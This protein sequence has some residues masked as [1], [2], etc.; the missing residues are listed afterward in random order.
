MTIALALSSNVRIPLLCAAA[1]L[2]A[3]SAP[4]GQGGGIPFPGALDKAAVIQTKIGDIHKEAMVVGNG[5]INAL[6]YSQAGD[7]VVR[8]TKNDVWDSRMDTSEDPDMPTVDVTSRKWTGSR[9]APPSWKKRPYP[10]QV[11]SCVIRVGAGEAVRKATLDLKRGLAEI[12][13]EAAA[14]RVRALWQRNVFLVDTAANVSLEGYKLKFLPPAESGTTDGIRW[15]RQTLP[16][17]GDYQGMSLA[18]ALGAAGRHKAVALVSSHDSATPLKGA[19][20][21]V[22][23]TL[24]EDPKETIRTHEGHWTTFWSASGVQLGIGDFQNWWYRQLYYFRCFSRPGVV[25]IG[26]QAGYNRPAGWHGSYKINYNI[27][28]TF[29]SPFTYNHPDLTKPWVEHLYGYL[30]RARWFARTGFGCEGAAYHAD[31]W[32]HEVDPAKC[33]NRNKNQIA[34]IPWGYTMG[35]SGMAVQN[36]WNYYLYK[37]DREYLKARIYPVIKEVAVFYASFLEQCKTDRDGKKIIG[38]SYNPEHGPFGTD[39]N[40]YDL[41]YVRYTLEAAIAAA[42]ALGVDQALARRLRRKLAL[43]P[44]YHTTPD[45]E[46]DNQRI[47]ANWRGAVHNSVRT[48]NITVPV[49]PLFPAEQFSWFSPDADK[50]LL[51]RTIRHVSQ[52]YNRNNSVVML[53]VARARLSMTNEAVTDAHKWFKARE[54]PNGLLHW[55]GHGYYMS[56]QVAV[57]A[58]VNEL[59]LQSVDR[60]V[61]VFPAW[62]ENR[63]AFFQ[64]LRAQGGFLVSA[65][66]TG[67]RVTELDIE[68]TVGGRLRLLSPWARIAVRTPSGRRLLEPDQRGVVQIETRAKERL[69][70]TGH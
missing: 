27:W 25:A 3:R 16:G 20:S 58:L 63:D 29:S 35:M 43:I 6:I 70:F 68:S 14:T 30:P 48:Y 2:C 7:I 67:G 60:V 5:D 55:K 41:A 8:V 1:I 4:A 10:I 59:L 56:E 11:P 23:R 44:A 37:P 21:L 34:Y 36:L 49:V 32:P 40:P 12:H 28:Q 47:I 50:A 57:G 65:T 9:G 38:P 19:I 53:N 62:P 33:R 31:T 46:Q 22:R 18:A 61:R 54:Q 39:D 15:I 13:D 51:T 24:H 42:R 52:R 17:H 64:G 26:L 66:Q 69:A 45:P